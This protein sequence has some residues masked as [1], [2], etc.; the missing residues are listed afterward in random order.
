MDAFINRTIKGYEFR[1]KLGEGG[2][3]AVYRAWQPSIPREV[4]IKVTPPQKA[5]QPDF[6]R[7]FEVEA[8]VIARLENPFIVPLFDY[9]RDPEGAFLVIR[10]FPSSLQRSIERGAWNLESAARLL[11]QMAAALTAAHR[12]GIVHRDIK[13][14]NIL[15]DEDE[16]AYLADFGIAQDIH[17]RDSA[18][19][20]GTDD[21][22]E[23]SP[24]YITPEVLKGGQITARTDIYSLGYVLYESLTGSKPFPDAT[25][26]SEYFQRH[27][28][29]PLPMMSIQQANIPAAVDEV[30][31][32]ATA[33]DP[34]HRYPTALRFAAAFRAAL[35][36]K[37][38]RM[39][40]Q[41]LVDPLTE[42][43]LDVL[44]LMVDGLSNQE[45]AE[46]LFLTAQT[47][48]WYVKQIYDKLDA[49]SRPRAIE[50]AIA[51]RLFES[52]AAAPSVTPVADTPTMRVIEPSPYAL[53]P[54]NPYKGLRAFQEA[55][56]ADFYG[57]AALTERLLSRLSE[58]DDGARFLVVVGPSGSG[59]SSVVRAG[60]LPALRRGELA[61]SPHPF[62]A[63]LLPGTH[64]LEELEAALLRVSINPIPG[65]LDQLQE[66]RRGLVR[67][68]KRI[69]PSDPS[70]ELIL[71][72][73][74]FE[75]IFTLVESDAVRMQ[76]IDNL[77]S[78]A[79][80]PRGRVRVILTLRADFYDRPLA[81]P[82]L[83]ELVRSHTEVIIPM[84][85]R[86]ME[87]AISAP[88]ERVGVRLESGLAATII[89]DVGE[90]P[91]SLPLLQYALTELFERREGLT[92]TLD[93]YKQTGGVLGALARR[94]DEIY[95]GLDSDG[96]ALARQMFMRLVTL[97]E[98]AE[99]TR[100]RALLAELTGIYSPQPPTPSP[101][102]RRGE[103][104]TSNSPLTRGEGSEV[105]VVTITTVGLPLSPLAWERG[106]G[107]E[108]QKADLMEDVV[109]AFAEYRLLTLDRDPLTHSPTVEIAHEALIREWSRLREWLNDSREDIRMQRRLA[110]A[111]AEWNAGGD[112]SFLASGA[113]LS[114]FESFATNT[115]LALTV[116]E[117]AYLEASLAE[118]ER[119]QAA[120][121]Q[122]QAHERQIERR[123]VNRLR[124]L[125]AVLVVGVIAALLLS[126]IAVSQGNEARAN[127]NRAEQQR[128]YLEA[129]NAMDDGASGNVGMA[130]AL[131]S[132]AY[133][134]TP[135]ADTA[136]M[137][138][139]RLGSVVFDLP[140]PTFD[141]YS[142][143]YSPDDS[144]IASSSEGGTWIYDAVTGEELQVLPDE[145]VVFSAVFS[146]DG[147]QLVTAGVLGTARLWD[148]ETWQEIQ[149]YTPDERIYDAFF[150][151][152][153]S[154]IIMNTEN[155]QQVWDAAS[156]ELLEHY[157]REIGDDTVRFAL[158]YGVSNRPRFMI[159]E[160]D[161]IYIQDVAT[162]ETLCTLVESVGAPIVGWWWSETLPY[163]MIRPDQVDGVFTAY[164]WDY[165]SCTPIFQLVESENPIYSVDYDPVHDVMVTVD[166]AGT[167]THWDFTSGRQ[168][169]QYNAPT[170]A[171]SLDISNDGTRLILP[172]YANARVVNLDYP[173]QPTIVT[174]DLFDNTNYPRFAPDNESVYIG[175]FGAAGHYSLDPDA[176]NPL[177]T[178]EQPLR[179]FDVSPDGQYL[180]A[181]IEGD[182]D[183][184]FALYWI[185]AETG[186]TVR[187]FEG[188]TQ[189]ANFVDI[190]PDGTRIASGS[191]D[192]T[193]RIWD[194]TTG[195]QLQVLEG[196]T[197]AV[198]S[199]TF[200][201][202]GRLL[203]TT[204]T[205]GTLR[206]WDVETGAS[207]RVMELGATT[208]Y[209]VFSPDATMIAVSDTD[210]FTHIYDAATGEERFR[211][212]G[213]TDIVWIVNFSP[214]SRYLVTASWDGRASIWDTQTGELVRMLDNGMGNPLYWAEFS[215]DGKTILTGS[216]R[217]DQVYLW[218]VSLDD[219]IAEMCAQ[220]LLD[221]SP[222][223][224]EQ[225]G[226]T[227]S[228]PVCP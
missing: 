163:L 157:P 177:I 138:A 118:R 21:T 87:Q 31:Q 88:A 106:A 135:E 169:E 140:G 12:E 146:P 129:D 64:P 111:A 210:G 60:L 34:S 176:N 199:A 143:S 156:G 45:I 25:T 145:A 70:T 227:D 128:L 4:A 213:H 2:M 81:M 187:T 191:F 113:R 67:A 19:K 85:A 59:K 82:R 9:W 220:P 80:D 165:E 78:A 149:S 77:L 182:A 144:L 92:L 184:D 200:S 105:R 58:K 206:V 219:V 122:R 175:G 26:P 181:S 152:D 207:V 202:D 101:S 51:L 50:R 75:E 98:G 89:N 46:K 164:V 197:G 104:D 173:Q 110:Q 99:D 188:F 69:L 43:E 10:C 109:N 97:G 68:A 224:R 17:L 29:D 44:R 217:D 35:P 91:G 196:H 133:G 190:S 178:Y 192:L 61:Q 136:L 218:R 198:S 41:P 65:L 174:T 223:Q 84:S 150:T 38:P 183:E 18:I 155:E 71:V 204:G 139:S 211:L 123:S 74:Q 107:G 48:K 33:K 47:V 189:T 131:R 201:P 30:L 57:R 125:V 158:L 32:T 216:E 5:N 72:V 95:G 49:R 103:N 132:L 137:R 28:N 115:D 116:E 167:V 66:D 62:I 215:P 214:D 221:L 20:E 179:G 86:E 193:A 119:Q 36:N 27:L 90:Q 228:D 130:L 124:S 117:R 14:A 94:A 24:E 208:I 63:D 96:Q 55:D 168:T 3:G 205:D 153:G 222:E 22:I 112:S 203:V 212:V 195:E 170:N 40:S 121:Q 108:G 148:V 185:D 6:V 209:A 16:N 56:A 42:R 127:F 161:R 147:S 194:T 151:P 186:E 162:G 141:V 37:L 100:R 15:L 225:Y 1:E 171:R 120:E 83:A 73:D 11:D 54:D 23:G 102:G 39:P 134:Y 7:R 126:G 13:P 76:F 142:V 52:K 180:G 154:R 79:T 226:I 166:S 114:Q 160:G 8:Q 53:E 172:D 93:G 159:W